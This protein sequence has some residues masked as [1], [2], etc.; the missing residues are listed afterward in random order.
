MRGKGVISMK[1]IIPIVFILMLSGLIVY[2]NEQ[3]IIANK[4]Q[5]PIRLNGT[6]IHNP[7][8]MVN[9]NDRVYMQARELCN[10][11]GI[12]IEW[13][14]NE[15]TIEIMNKNNDGIEIGYNSINGW[16][17]TDNVYM[18]ITRETAITIADDVFLKIRGKDFIDNTVADIS[19]SSD[20]EYFYVSRYSDGLV[21]GNDLSIMI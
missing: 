4:V 13:N 16:T 20:G 6:I 1:K 3:S 14:Q 12:T 18:E 9:I 19:E 7:I 5:Y 11:L 15:N 10:V 17:P 8:E 2:A 21:L